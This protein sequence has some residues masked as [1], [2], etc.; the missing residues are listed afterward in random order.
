MSKCYNTQKSHLK[1]TKAG[2][3]NKSSAAINNYV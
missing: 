2:N 3:N 1:E